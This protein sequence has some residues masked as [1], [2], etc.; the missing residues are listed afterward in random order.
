MKEH[1]REILEKELPLVDLDSNCLFTELSSLDITQIMMLLSEEYKIPLEYHDVT[2]RH[3]MT[4]DS[5]VAMVQNKM[6]K[7]L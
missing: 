2:P 4:L 1:I 3:F 7:T 6:R 5:I